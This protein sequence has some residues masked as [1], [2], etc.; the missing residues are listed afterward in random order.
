M[1]T[2]ILVA[3]GQRLMREGLRHILEAREG[4][5]VVAEASNG[6]EAVGLAAENQPDIAVLETL[7]PQLSGPDAIKQIHG[8]S[9]QT[10]CIILSSQEDRSNVQRALKLG[11]AGY[12]VKSASSSEL[13]EAIDVVRSGRSYLSPTI[14]GHVIQILVCPPEKGQSELQLLTARERQVLQLVAEGLTSKE[15][16]TQL[17]VATKTADTHRAHLM[18]KLAIHKVSALVRFAIREGLVTA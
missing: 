6:L 2:R 7:L 16:A 4:F 13:L 1:K 15:I 17:C 10:R 14:A 9:K 5:H 11:A 3:D 12:V 18:E 8:K